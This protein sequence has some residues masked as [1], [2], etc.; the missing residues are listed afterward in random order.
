MSTIES[1]NASN[2]AAL[3]QEHPEG[4]VTLQESHD[5]E[6]GRVNESGEDGKIAEQLKACNISPL[7][8]DEKRVINDLVA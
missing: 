5:A 8:E 4:D 6:T 7:S 1:A 2:S 3:L